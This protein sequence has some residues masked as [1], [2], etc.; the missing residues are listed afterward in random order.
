MT[1]GAFHRLRE[2]T[3]EQEIEA[4]G[5]TDFYDRLDYVRGFG[6]PYSHGVLRQFSRAMAVAA[7]AASVCVPGVRL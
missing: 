2:R 4:L 5:L 1:R 7:Y 3:W 6:E